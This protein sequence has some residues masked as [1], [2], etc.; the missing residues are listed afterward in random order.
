MQRTKFKEKKQDTTLTVDVYFCQETG[1]VHIKIPSSNFR[2]QKSFSKL[3]RYIFDTVNRFRTQNQG[4]SINVKV[5][6]DLFLYLLLSKVFV[7]T[8]STKHKDQKDLTFSISSKN[9]DKVSSPSINQ[10]VSVAAKRKPKSNGFPFLEKTIQELPPKPKLTKEER[11]ASCLPYAIR[12]RDIIKKKKKINP[13][14]SILL[15]WATEIRKLS[16]TMGVEMERI[17]KVLD[18]YDKNIGGEYVPVI[19]SGYSLRMK[20]I[21]L[22]DA[23]TRIEYGTSPGQK[24]FV[25]D[26]GIRYNLCPD[27]YYRDTYGNLYIE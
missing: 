15:Q 3:E 18:W 21:R 19:E 13:T 9:I 7:G 2:T 22:E 5:S 14:H 26:D 20:F 1:D 27:G 11:T 6:K 10:G 17:E 24:K 25:I 8:F 23:M 4:Q 16:E 12:L